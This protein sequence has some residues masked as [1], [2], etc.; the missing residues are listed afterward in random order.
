M[1]TQHLQISKNDYLYRYE[2]KL[3][4]FFRLLYASMILGKKVMCLVTEGGE[5]SGPLFYARVICAS[6]FWKALRKFINFPFFV[7]SHCN[8]LRHRCKRLSDYQKHEV[9]GIP[10]SWNCPQNAVF[11]IKNYLTHPKIKSNWMIGHVQGDR[12]QLL[13]NR[14]DKFVFGTF[15]FVPVR[16]SNQ[17]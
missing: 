12:K 9:W 13:P 16:L 2:K 17:H 10:K 7:V 6:L 15:E 1:K 3:S 14:T 11:G 5:S 8:K 4:D